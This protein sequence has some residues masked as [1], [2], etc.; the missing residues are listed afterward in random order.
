MA[1]DAPLVVEQRQAARDARKNLPQ[2]RTRLEQLLVAFL[3][4][5]SVVTLR[6]VAQIVCLG[7]A[8]RGFVRTLIDYEQHVTLTDHRAL[9]ESNALKKSA[10]A[11]PDFDGVDRLEMTREFIPVGNLALDCRSD[12]DLR[13]LHRRRRLAASGCDDDDKR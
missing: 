3:L 4:R 9:D 7:L 10:D 11:R 8:Q 5:P 1:Q 6:L 13:S 2:L 12:G